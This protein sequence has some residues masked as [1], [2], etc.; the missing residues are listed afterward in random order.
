MTAQTEPVPVLDPDSPQAHAFLEVLADVLDEL[1]E[2]H[3][4]EAVAAR[5]AQ[6]A[7]A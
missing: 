4:L 2:K 5:R 7:T 3:A 6:P 1:D